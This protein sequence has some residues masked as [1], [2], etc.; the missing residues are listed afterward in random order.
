VTCALA[1]SVAGCGGGHKSASSRSTAPAGAPTT[2]TSPGSTLSDEVLAV[3]SVGGFYGRCPDGIREWTLRFV[4]G[5]PAT[6]QVV[7]QLGAGARHRASV[8]PGEALNFG[9]R[10]G[11][12]Q[13]REPADGA[14]HAPRGVLPTT[15][16]LTLAITQ[17][18]EP[19]TL[20]M[21]VQLALAATHDGS[22]RCALVAS[23][24]SARTY[25]H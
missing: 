19:H 16:P 4:N 20:R 11:S 18:T 9:L 22:S 8:Q 3:P 24:V 6:D 1:L 13:T 23:R 12:A 7:Y 25:F 14:A 5:S 2:S 17:A 10:P 21:D 15:P